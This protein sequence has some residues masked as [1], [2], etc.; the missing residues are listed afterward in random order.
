MVP[1]SVEIFAPVEVEG[2]KSWASV[3]A[4]PA[5]TGGN[6]TNVQI[7]LGANNLP[8]P[9][10][11]ERLREAAKRSGLDLSQFAHALRTALLQEMELLANVRAEALSTI[12]GFR[13]LAEMMRR[14]MNA[15]AMKLREEE[16]KGYPGLKASNLDRELKILLQFLEIQKKMGQ[17]AD[18]T[19]DAEQKRVGDSEAWRRRTDI[20]LFGTASEGSAQ[21]GSA[22]VSR[23]MDP[24]K[25][26]EIADWLGA[27]QLLGEAKSGVGLAGT[28]TQN[29]PVIQ[30]EVERAPSTERGADSASVTSSG[31]RKVP[32]SPPAEIV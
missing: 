23:I 21:P 17:I 27:P 16:L 24:D 18:L 1:S 7:N 32:A 2:S 8:T 9:E 10:D 25:Q 14:R 26:A 13:S 5:K 4:P 15:L 11:V 29:S 20:L 3:L 6:Q 28:P 19:I 31:A 12:K 22:A 30:A